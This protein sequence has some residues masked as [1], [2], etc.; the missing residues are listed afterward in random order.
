MQCLL[1]TIVLDVQ[2]QWQRKVRITT[3]CLVNPLLFRCI[4]LIE[5]SF[6]VI[7]NIHYYRLIVTNCRGFG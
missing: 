1:I 4:T 5:Q 7:A 3:H 6:Y 2:Q